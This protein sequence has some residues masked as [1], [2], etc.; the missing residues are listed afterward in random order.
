M[1]LLL[2]ALGCARRDSADGNTVPIRPEAEIAAAQPPT[3]PS[4]IDDVAIATRWLDALREGNQGELTAYV[5]FPFE[6]HDDGGFC[7]NQT[8]SAAEQLPAV[9]AC[10][11]NDR[12]LI[13][14]LRRHDSAAV[15]PLADVHLPAWAKKWHVTTTPNQRI[16][17]GFF[18]RQDARVHLDL[19]VIDGGVR[20]VWR[21][22]VNG[23]AAIAIA[24]EW[25]DAL[26]NRDVEHLARVTS[27]PFEVRD[28]R[29]DAKCGKRVAK[30]PDNLPATVDCL[31]RSDLLHRAMI[32]SPEPGFSAYEASES[33]ANWIQPWWRDSEHRGLQRVATMVAT[34]DGDQ[35]DFQMLVA[36]DGVRTVWKA[37]SFESR[38]CGPGLR[39]GDYTQHLGFRSL[40]EACGRA[41][42]SA[43]I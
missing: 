20:G 10:L 7:K 31:L 40:P 39:G 37:G 43:E 22:G 25:L 26:I 8:A 29:R 11:S 2:L 3:T 9:L 1:W 4:P 16:V 33:L 32:D 36:P 6:I 18:D 23:S 35:F 28:T 24:T 41:P 12:D 30:G 13:D 42:K 21:S 27:Y 14:V 38:N 17:T 19:W 34:A 5:R 15:E